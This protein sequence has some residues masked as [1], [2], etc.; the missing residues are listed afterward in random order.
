MAAL[1]AGLPVSRPAVSQHLKILKE[2]GL[3]ADEAAGRAPALPRGSRRDDGL[4]DLAGGFLE[5]GLCRIIRPK[6][7]AKWTSGETP[8]TCIAGG[9]R[10]LQNK[11][12]KKTTV[13][14]NYL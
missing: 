13:T 8:E 7:S 11:Y 14:L 9:E 10:K 12:D 5:S 3:V 2:A 6:F 1:A 4:A